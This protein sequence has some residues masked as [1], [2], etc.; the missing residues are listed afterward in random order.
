M[1]ESVSVWALHYITKGANCPHRLL[2]QITSTSLSLRIPVYCNVACAQVLKTIV[3]SS[4]AHEPRPRTE[5]QSW[6]RMPHRSSTVLG[7]VSRYL[8]YGLLRGLSYPHH[9]TPPPTA[10]DRRAT[11]GMG[12]QGR[13]QPRRHRPGRP[14]RAPARFP[15][16]PARAR[17]SSVAVASRAAPSAP[18][19]PR[20]PSPCH[21]GSLLRPARSPVRRRPV[22][23]SRICGA[24]HLRQIKLHGFRDAFEV[25]AAPYLFHKMFMESET[26]DGRCSMP[27]ARICGRTRC[28][29]PRASF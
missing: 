5:T 6:V 10:P 28:V 25:F 22:C 17:A 11:P 13:L 24:A 26:C 20:A 16:H 27:N 8:A 19:R 1:L 21:E 29:A 2:S 18:P 9:E 4:T 7:T 3:Y 12:G 23:R 15:P 14:G